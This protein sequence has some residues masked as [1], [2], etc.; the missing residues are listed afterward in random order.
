MEQTKEIVLRMKFTTRRLFWVLA[1]AFF[2]WRPGLLDSSQS[3]VMTSYYPAP[4][5][6]YNQ[7]MSYGDTY[8]GERSGA[9]VTLARN[10]GYVCIGGGT[11]GA[12]KC[13]GGSKN[14]L[15]AYSDAYFGKGLSDSTFNTY[16]VTHLSNDQG[17]VY[18]GENVTNL[19]TGNKG[20]FSK[21]PFQTNSWLYIGGTGAND[22][23]VN[24]N[25]GIFGGFG[26]GKLH[27][28]QSYFDASAIH[29]ANRA[30]TRSARFYLR[31]YGF[32]L[33]TGLNTDLVLATYDG[34][35][36]KHALTIMERQGNVI[37]VSHGKTYFTKDIYLGQPDVDYGRIP[38][39]GVQIRNMCYYEQFGSHM[40]TS[41]SYPGVS[42]CDRGFNPV[43]F[44]PQST[45]IFPSAIKYKEGSHYKVKF[46]DSNAM[47]AGWIVCCAVGIGSGN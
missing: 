16:G 19:D 28:V 32:V 11:G 46:F 47:S 20:I 4:Y 24:N 9:K 15:F 6:G 10:G 25:S 14:A 45:A 22:Y 1:L 23:L 18:F 33:Q 30:K 2:V 35:V 37:N 39:H 21:I 43:G 8:L 34:V 41:F 40:Y 13:P 5:G 42:K 17:Q 3:L 26:R 31:D 27:I 44:L 36:G 7:L 38:N 12:D 29:I